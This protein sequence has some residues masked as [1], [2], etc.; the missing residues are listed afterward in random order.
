MNRKIFVSL[1]LTIIFVSATVMAHHLA[2]EYGSVE[3]TI[4]EG[5][6]TPGRYTRPI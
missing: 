4:E 5:P 1:F 6:I 3:V 2:L